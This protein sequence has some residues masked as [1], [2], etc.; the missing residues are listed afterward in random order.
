VSPVKLTDERG[1]RDGGGTKSYK[2]EEAW[3]ALNYSIL[4]VAA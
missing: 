4:S 3:P 2:L 1:G